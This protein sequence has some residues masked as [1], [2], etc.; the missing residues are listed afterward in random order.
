MKNKGAK[1]VGKNQTQTDTPIDYEGRLYEMYE[2][3]S[4]EDPV[5]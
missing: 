1:K 5:F 4:L 2:L 3:D